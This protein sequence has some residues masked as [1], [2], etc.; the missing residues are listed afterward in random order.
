MSWHNKYSPLDKTFAHLEWL[1]DQMRH[2]LSSGAENTPEDYCA[3]MS[4]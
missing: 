2:E 1:A 4:L 3:A